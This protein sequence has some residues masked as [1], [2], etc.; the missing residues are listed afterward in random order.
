LDASPFF[1]LV[2]I[3][4]LPP[5]PPPPPPPIPP[6]T[7]TP[8]APR[9]PNPDPTL[10]L[11]LLLL[12][13]LLLLLPP[14]PPP[15]PPP[16]APTNPTTSSSSSLSLSSSRSMT[17]TAAT[18]ALLGGGFSALCRFRFSLRTTGAVIFFHSSIAARRAWLGITRL[19]PLRA[20]PVFGQV[21][22]L[23]S[24][25]S[26]CARS[27]VCWDER[28]MTGSAIVSKLTGQQKASSSSIPRYCSVPVAMAAAVCERWVGTKVL[29]QMKNVISGKGF[30]ETYFFDF[31]SAVA[32]WDHVVVVGCSRPGHG[33]H[34]RQAF[35]PWE[36]RLRLPS[37]ISFPH[38]RAHCMYRAR[39]A[40]R[41]P[42]QHVPPASPPLRSLPTPVYRRGFP[43]SN[44]PTSP[45]LHAHTR[46]FP[47]P[48]AMLPCLYTPTPA[49][50]RLLCP[51]P[52]TSLPPATFPR[53]HAPLP[54]APDPRSQTYPASCA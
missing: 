36:V 19:S 32:S 20:T 5:P 29:H 47:S 27:K 52:L 30:F 9:V 18:A 1:S 35:P 48:S 10:R 13:L 38:S 12:L 51:C 42:T 14:P 11:P 41:E 3:L 53:A 39:L 2:V 37:L 23:A 54:P 43:S 25:A 26:R 34:R 44:H 46:T 49:L 33:V 50:P 7:S 22:L 28:R 45:P 6:P 17:P 8:S 24:H 21:S 15:P 40:V 16:L 4:P 31:R